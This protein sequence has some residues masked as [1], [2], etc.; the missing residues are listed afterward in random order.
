MLTG[1]LGVLSPASMGP[2]GSAADGESVLRS[3]IQANPVSKEIGPTI[4]YAFWIAVLIVTP[5]HRVRTGG[6]RVES[7]TRGFCRV[8]HAST[9]S[10]LCGIL[11]RHP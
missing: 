10:A 2:G 9:A 7:V 11:S 1:I 5:R 4:A 6:A 8:S 3:L